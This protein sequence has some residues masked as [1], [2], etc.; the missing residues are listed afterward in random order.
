MTRAISQPS[1][2]RWTAAGILSCQRNLLS[3]V[4][5]LFSRGLLMLHFLR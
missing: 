1:F 3:G 5:E 4:L 2:V